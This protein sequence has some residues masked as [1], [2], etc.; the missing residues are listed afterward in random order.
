MSPFCRSA[1]PV[2]RPAIFLVSFFMMPMY[3]LVAGRAISRLCCY[4]R[5]VPRSLQSLT[6]PHGTKTCHDSRRTECQESH[7][8]YPS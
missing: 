1:P 4:K 8:A 5:P 7:F 3:P 6:S 2:E